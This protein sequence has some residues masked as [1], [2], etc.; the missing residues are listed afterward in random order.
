MKNLWPDSFAENTKP[1]AKS[2]LEEQAKLLPKITNGIVFAEVVEL[3]RVESI[4]EAMY[5]EFCY[6]LNIRG[7]FLEGYSFK[8][9]S[10]SHDITL[11]PVEFHLDEQLAEELRIRSAFNTKKIDNPEELERFL[12]MVLTSNR[13]KNVVGSILKLSK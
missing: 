4:R 1:S 10:F 11:Y 3:D 13:I 6:R 7:K 2:L 9:M 8:V 5:N 12:G